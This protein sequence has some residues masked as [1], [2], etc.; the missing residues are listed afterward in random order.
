MFDFLRDAINLDLIA[1]DRPLHSKPRVLRFALKLQQFTGPLMAKSMEDTAF[2]RFPRVLAFNEVGGNPESSGLSIEA[3]HD[4]MATRSAQWPHGLTATATH[5]TKRGEDARTRLTAL[6]ELAPEWAH[7]VGRWKV[8]NARFI[9]ATGGQRSP[10]IADEYFIYQ[11]LIGALP[12]DPL[13][14]E[15]IERIKAYLQK[16]LREAKLHTSWLNPH[17]DY[18]RG[19]AQFIADILNPDIAG[20]FIASLRDFASRTALIGAL[21]TLTQLTLKATMPGVPDFYQGTELW[22]FSLVDPDNRRP[23][24]FD[25]RGKLAGN[26]TDDWQMLSRDWKSGNLKFAW[27]RHLLALRHSAAEVF[28]DGDHA[29]L[30]VTGRHRDHVI[31]Y[32]RRHKRKAALIIALRCFAP[33]TNGGRHWPK[34][35]SIDAQISLQHFHPS[36]RA[37]PGKD[38]LVELGTILDQFPVAVWLAEPRSPAGTSRRTEMTLSS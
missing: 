33:F 38:G 25:L 26:S 15:F 9:H 24:D 7:V 13:T 28:T 19:V 6:A 14:A 29:P 11:A 2:Y 31:A 30:T 32:V 12:S 22:D 4:A 34:F 23:V 21:N 5:D 3:F 20:E 35:D 8:L 36:E 37:S 16:A 10:D 1:R 17:E 27:T 18:E